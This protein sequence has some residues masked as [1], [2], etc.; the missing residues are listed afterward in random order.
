MQHNTT[1]LAT[2]DRLALRLGSEDNFERLKDCTHIRATR[3]QLLAIGYHL[4]LSTLAEHCGFRV[5]VFAR[6]E[7]FITMLESYEQKGPDLMA[8]LEA[9]HEAFRKMPI[10]MDCFVFR[11]PSPIL[12]PP[13][14]EIMAKVGSVDFDDPRP[15]LTLSLPKQ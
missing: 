11:V 1:T 2:T 14:L 4:E 15:A 13:F 8:M 6:K 3:S 9:L 7:V 10:Q 5:R 12:E